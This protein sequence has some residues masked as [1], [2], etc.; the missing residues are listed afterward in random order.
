MKNA[1]L[2]T[3]NRKNE[4][5]ILGSINS[6]PEKTLKTLLVANISDKQKERIFI[7]LINIET[8]DVKAFS[9]M[10]TRASAAPKMLRIQFPHHSKMSSL[11]R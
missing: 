2:A 7:K 9:L 6:P 5:Q 11:R 10:G 8:E 1:D 4:F 3:I